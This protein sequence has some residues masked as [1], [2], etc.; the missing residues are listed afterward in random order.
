VVIAAEHMIDKRYKWW[1]K[2]DGDKRDISWF[3]DDFEDQR[4]LV[5][6][7][8]NEYYLAA[9]LFENLSTDAEVHDKAKEIVPTILSVL[10]LQGNP[11]DFR[12]AGKVIGFSK[13]GVQNLSVI[14]PEMCVAKVRCNTR[15]KL[16]IMG[17]D[18]VV[19]APLRPP[20]IVVWLELA[21]KYEE[22]NECL[23]Y[24]KQNTWI[25]FYKVYE[26]L[27]DDLA[28]GKNSD[29]RKIKWVDVKQLDR[30]TQDA[31][32]KYAIGDAARHAKKKYKPSDNPMTFEEAKGFISTL[33]KNWL[34]EKSRT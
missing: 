23:R 7:H 9:E 16:S 15:G 27:I 24:F 22:V 29:F 31:Q 20:N 13:D 3:K 4:Y 5:C 12:Y 19:K 33:L 34:N 17:P 6:K 18:G 28:G 8:D 26:M 14:R 10:T 11:C 21:L 1:V 2:L 32:S 25:S 30:F